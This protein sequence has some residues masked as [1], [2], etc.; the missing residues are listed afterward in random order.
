MRKAPSVSYPL[1]PSVWAR[2]PVGALVLAW[3]AGLV[4]WAASDGAWP[5]SAWWW[6]SVLAGVALLA[7]HGRAARTPWRG[8]LVWSAGDGAW[9]LEPEVRPTARAP[10]RPL[11][12]VQ[13]A[14]DAQR[15]MLLRLVPT[16]GMARWVA[17]E[18]AQAPA[19][20]DDLRR[21]VVAARGNAAADDARV[22]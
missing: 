1:G 6:T 10:A 21:A 14:L 17:V 19:H 12:E 13:L 22:V 3:A 18:R 5:E 16:Q 4:I 8:F 7:W 9:R 20:W 2:W 15:V 11:R